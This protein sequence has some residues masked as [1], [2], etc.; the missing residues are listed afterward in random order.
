MTLDRC[1]I[2]GCNARLQST[3]VREIYNRDIVIEVIE[4]GYD[5]IESTWWNDGDTVEERLYCEND[6]PFEAMQKHLADT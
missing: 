5:I 6:H 2:P 1:P 3:E 4:G